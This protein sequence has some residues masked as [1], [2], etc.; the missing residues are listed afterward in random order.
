MEPSV[1]ITDGILEVVGLP[2][3]LLTGGAEAS[4]FKVTVGVSP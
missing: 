2:F 1:L 4:F 3:P